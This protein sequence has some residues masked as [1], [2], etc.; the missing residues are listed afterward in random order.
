MRDVL[1]QCVDFER[2]N[3]APIGILLT[4]TNVRTG[5]GRVFRNADLTPDVLL[6]SA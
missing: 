6:A 1:E 5:R 4:A 2:L 3:T